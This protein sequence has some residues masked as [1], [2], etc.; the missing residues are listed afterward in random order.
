MPLFGQLAAAPHA[1]HPLLCIAH[2][3][4]CCPLH[5]VA[6]SEQAST[7]V[8]HASPMQDLPFAQSVAVPQWKHPSVPISHD[9]SCTPTHFVSLTEQSSVHVGHAPFT[10]G[11]PPAQFVGAFQPVQPLACSEHV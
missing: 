5:C 6:P 10:H 11:L 1:V 9:A 4:T 3:C 2:V 8:G 7:H